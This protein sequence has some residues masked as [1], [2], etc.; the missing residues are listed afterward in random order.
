MDPPDRKVFS[1]NLGSSRRGP[2]GA[3]GRGATAVLDRLLGLREMARIH[4]Q[5][6]GVDRPEEFIRWTLDRLDVRVKVTA[7]DLLRFPDT[8]P[9]IIVANHPF[10]GIEGMILAMLLRWVREDFRILAN[11]FLGRIPE[12]AE[13]FILVDPFGGRD[14]AGRNLSALREARRWLAADGLLGIFPSGEVAHLRLRDLRVTD[15][16]WSETV[17]RLARRGR[18]PVVP[19]YF[20]GRNSALFQAAGL[21]HPRLRTILLGRELLRR[22]GGTIEV[23]IGSPIPHSRLAGI[24]SDGKMVAYLRDRTEILGARVEASLDHAT[25]VQP[26]VTPEEALPV[27]DAVPEPV[28]EEEIEGLP[29]DQLLYESE[30]EQ[31]LVA[32]A[33]QI[34]RALREIGRLREIT[35]REVG[36]GTGREI[37]IDRFDADYEHLFIWNRA[38]SQIVGAYR[39]GRTDEL[40]GRY[41]PSGLYT[42]SLFEFRPQLFRKIGPALE[43]GR[44]FVRPEHQKSYGPLVLLWKGI[45]R[46]VVRNPRY[47]ALFGPVSISAEYTSASQRL[48]VAFLKQ[49]RF[50]HPW[51]RY[52]RPRRPFR[53]LPSRKPRPRLANLRGLD[54]VSSFI[55]EIE[56][57]H[58]GAPILLKQYLKLGGRLL[59]FNVD[60][61]FSNVLDVLIMVDLRRTD[62]KILGRYM[63][64][65]GRDEF[66][67]HHPGGDEPGEVTVGQEPAP[68]PPPGRTRGR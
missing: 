60:P 62:P 65:S 32:R 20:G 5:A 7:G 1:L 23:R 41:G 33:E 56:S 58:K 51:S 66:L 14:S 11:Y 48:M 36:E 39:I 52:V 8:G 31:V 9:A 59:G 55:S 46:Y 49:N 24:D 35:F 47:A 4:E 37:D 17:A 2:G 61:D 28:L 25:P 6:G 15:P 27:A 54:D 10:G 12:L 21:I 13:L 64:R 45:G 38:R 16:P 40:L 67:R 50:A 68:P 43:M 30:D 26:R 42:A 53:R 44:S 29:G 3:L 19:V 57:D 22:R 34:P 18:C 63:G